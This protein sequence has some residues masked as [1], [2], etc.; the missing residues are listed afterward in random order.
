[1]QS[2]FNKKYFSILVFLIQVY[3]GVISSCAP[4]AVPTGGSV[5]PWTFAVVSDT[6][7]NNKA[8]E[9]HSCI[10]DHIVHAIADDLAR[11]H[12]DLVL[13]SGDLVNGWLKNSDTAYP[14]QYQNWKKAMAAVYEAGIRVY[15]IRGNHDSGPERLVLPPL[16]A[17][18]E[19]PDG[20]LDQLKKTFQKTF[21]E[22]YIPQNSPVGEQG[23][24]YSF[25]HKN[26]FFVGLDQYSNGQHKVN[27]AWLDR[28]LRNN[29]H[30]HIFIYG[31]EPAFE[32]NHKD[33]LS[34]FQKLRDI[35]WDSIGQAGAVIYFCG[36]DHFY[37]RALI[38]DSTGH[39]LRQ[40]VVSPGGG[41]LRTW[42][43]RYEESNRV[44]RE[45][46]NEKFY[47]YIL[48]T[49][50]GLHATVR[51]K[52]LTRP[53]DMYSWQ[54]LDTFSYSLKPRVNALD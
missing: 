31:H 30:P 46:H 9:S 45:Y 5:Q 18:L 26:A 1:M 2:L 52:A 54:F 37:N 51:W 32:M 4:E 7:G 44:T 39:P 15:P 42:S 53:E 38:P 21:S 41:R 11:E 43:G 22:A 24:T 17:H 19:P 29:T 40:I 28:Q 13:V 47:G 16:P 49:V 50:E 14:V 10:N 36:H 27:Q 25:R 35:F 20:A 33:N 23:L 48:V 6:Q 12:P 34:C 8:P 3:F